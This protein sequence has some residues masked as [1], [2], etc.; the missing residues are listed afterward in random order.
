LPI[1][2]IREATHDLIDREVSCLGLLIEAQSPSLDVGRLGVDVSGALIH[3]DNQIPT[4]AAIIASP[5]NPA[6]NR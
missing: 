4:C 2:L 1:L 3:F 5:T 6:S